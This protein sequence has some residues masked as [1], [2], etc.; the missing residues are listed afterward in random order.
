MYE[1]GVVFHKVC[2]DM[3]IQD[4]DT[5]KYISINVNGQMFFLRI[6]A[7]SQHQKSNILTTIVHST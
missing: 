4:R 6:E 7:K 2:L 5:C 1:S 3:F